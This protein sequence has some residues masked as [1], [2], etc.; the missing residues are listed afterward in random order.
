MMN[1]KKSSRYQVIRYMVLGLL[2]GGTVLSLNYTRAAEVMHGNKGKSPISHGLKQ[3]AAPVLPVRSS[4]TADSVPVVIS[5]SPNATIIS[6][7]VV[8]SGKDST[9]KAFYI[10]NGKA[11]DKA[12]ENCGGCATA[13]SNDSTAVVFVT[14][15]G[16]QLSQQTSTITGGTADVQVI[17]N[18]VKVNTQEMK[19]AQ[20][21]DIKTKTISGNSTFTTSQPQTITITTKPMVISGGTGEVTIKIDTVIV[22]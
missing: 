6:S 2:V 4:V 9:G 17:V 22:K 14:I 16:D 18:G 11:T 10:V 3:A 5:T 21:Y 19:P 13:K 7:S 1:S 15:S 8:I 20:T 12:P